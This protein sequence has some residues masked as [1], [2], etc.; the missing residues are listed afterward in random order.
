MTPGGGR[1]GGGVGGGGGKGVSGDDALAKKTED[2]A[3]FGIFFSC[4]FSVSFV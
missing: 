4:F 1:G 3:V 2:F